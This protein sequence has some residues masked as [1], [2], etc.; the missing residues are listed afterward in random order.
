[1]HDIPA[2]IIHT[3]T[4]INKGKYR[5]VRHFELKTVKNG[6]SVLSDRINLQ[7]DRQFAKSFPKYWLK[8]RKGKK[9]SRPIT[10]LFDTDRPNLFHGD[11][12][13][14]KHLIIVHIPNQSGQVSIYYFQ[15]YFTLNHADI[16]TQIDR[17]IRFKELGHV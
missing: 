10:G 11:S 5:S 2:P 3:Y 1:M 9:W 15:N 13:Y 4:E 6:K 8:I 14:K 16:V 7:K 12:Q 17:D